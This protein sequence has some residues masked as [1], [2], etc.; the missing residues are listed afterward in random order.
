GKREEA[1]G[2]GLFARLLHGREHGTNAPEV[3]NPALIADVYRRYRAALVMDEENAMSVMLPSPVP[4]RRIASRPVSSPTAFVRELDA[5]ID[6]WVGDE[7]IVGTVALVALDGE[8]VYR[9]AAGYADREAGI[10]VTEETIFRLASMTKL[11]VS[12]AA[13][14]LEARGRL[15][16]TDTVERWLPYF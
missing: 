16:I 10:A 3:S 6:A 14:A 13:M 9:R 15:D 5:V 1:D 12:A 7:R 4:A 2:D 8:P 11:I